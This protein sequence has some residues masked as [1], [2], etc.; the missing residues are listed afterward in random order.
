[1]A[2][3]TPFG[4]PLHRLRLRSPGSPASSDSGITSS[5]WMDSADLVERLPLAE[6]VETDVCI[7]GGGIAGLSTAYAL[8]KSGARVIVLDDGPL[9]GGETCRTTAHL[10]SAL[11]DRYYEL[12][13][14]HG[15]QGAR[16]A[17]Q[18]HRAAIDAIERITA[19]MGD[20]CDFER[21]DGYLF[22]A[23]AGDWQLLD[24]ELAAAQR[25]GL[26]VTKVASAP[27][28][29]VDTG[30]AL[31]FA[32]QAQFHPLR[33]LAALARSIEKG[34]GRLVRAHA[35][36]FRGGRDS[37][38]RTS[39]GYT[40]AARALVIA[41]NTPVNDRVTMHTKQAPYRTY[42]VAF[43]VP[44]GDLAR[45]L[46]WDTGDPYH[47]VRL[48]S[49]DAET[50]ML[51][52]GGEDH[53][54][55]QADDGDKR[56]AR[57]ER[58]ARR[59]FPSAGPTEYRWSGQVMEPVDSLGFIGR[60]PGDDSNVFIATGDS[61]NGM[62]HGTI[63]GLLLSDLIQGRTN[64]WAALYDPSRKNPKTL[65]EFAREAAA[66][67][68]GYKGWVT[69]GDVASEQQIPPGEGAVMR[70]GL[71]KLAVYCDPGGRITELSAVCPHLGCIVEWNS[72]E[73]TWDCPCHGSRFATDG[74]VVNGPAG[75]GL[76]PAR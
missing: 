65:G 74:H 3:V 41:T 4:Q 7:V 11:D 46:F 49:Y 8:V 30:P 64:P 24:R 9:G 52:V 54:T 10:T 37:H 76:S 16:I 6:D 13:R 43:P 56:F 22:P 35:E 36:V 19:E 63:A 14:V 62:T 48:Q 5:V 23:S 29:P 70:R 72:T 53:R 68:V 67:Q 27:I 40:V 32:N 50:D 39:D 18:S 20:P 61:G 58:W 25:A 45:A 60:N 59:H 75:K 42:V 31:R 44:R 33:Y 57:L 21:L 66:S 55:G 12:E 2:E 73:K 28:D 1:M 38:V 71:A 51:I 15:E 47:Y 69:G 17:A 34:G 26:E